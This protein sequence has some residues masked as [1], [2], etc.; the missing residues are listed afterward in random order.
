V[1]EP[2][3]YRDEEA[4]VTRSFESYEAL[5]AGA[6]RSA[7]DVDLLKGITE[8]RLVFNHLVAPLAGG[9]VTHDEAAEM[10]D[11]LIRAAV[12]ADRTRRGST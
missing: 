6:A 10:I 5:F 7:E 8:R 3:Q 2:Q 4:G 1:S 11:N 9:P 12:L